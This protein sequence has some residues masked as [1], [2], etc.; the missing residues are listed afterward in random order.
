MTANAG[1]PTTRTPAQVLLESRQKESRQKR[2]AVEQQLV[3]MLADGEPITFIKVA[4]RAK[5]STWLVYS[6]GTR[7]QIQEAIT[8]QR[9]PKQTKTQP[10]GIESLR[11]DL[12]LARQEIS[13]LRR[14]REDL[15]ASLRQ[16]LGRQLNNLSTA[17]LVDRLNRLAGELAE[18]R[19]SNAELNL[20]IIGLQEDLT[21]AR[22]S[23]R[24]MIREQNTDTST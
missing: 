21:A 1:K 18:A 14:E 6:P 22:T 10:A 23:L 8:K 2:A 12:A 16:A 19:A 13:T 20:Q 15:R 7:E 3:G 5:V 11:T 24:R 9:Q 17:P 4:R